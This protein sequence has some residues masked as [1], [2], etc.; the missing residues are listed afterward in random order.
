MQIQQPPVKGCPLCYSQDCE[1]FHQ[2][3][4]REYLRCGVCALVHVPARYHLA[5][6]EERA[7]YDLH[8]NDIDDA[9]YRS[10]LSRLATPLVDR[11]QIGSHGLDF[12]CGPGPALASVLR[13]EGFKMELYDPFYY[14]DNSKLECQYDFITATE[15]VEHLANPGREL[16]SLWQ[17]LP[18][19]G[20]LG[21]MT[22][23]VINRD[24]FATWHYIRD[25][26]HICFFSKKTFQWLANQLNAD[27]EYFSNDIIL[28]R[29]R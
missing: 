21:V 8:C 14:P 10:F 23:L 17:L 13:K 3:A 1:D 9:G 5:A 29:K 20:L 25:P 26:T 4:H 22:K 12:G 18:D 24:R 28:L 19:G 15:V 16:K 2:D 7:Q 11:V 27:T 6:D